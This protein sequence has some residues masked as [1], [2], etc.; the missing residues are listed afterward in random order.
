MR[1]DDPNITR[2]SKTSSPGRVGTISTKPEAGYPKR[3]IYSIKKEIMMTTN[4]VN[5]PLLLHSYTT[6][7]SKKREEIK[8]QLSH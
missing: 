4:I 5:R 3:I 6:L 2:N 7:E 8:I 1:S